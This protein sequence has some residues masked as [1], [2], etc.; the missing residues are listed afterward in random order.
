MNDSVS[1]KI[2]QYKACSRSFAHKGVL[3]MSAPG[4]EAASMAA[5]EPYGCGNEMQGRG[6]REARS[7]KPPRVQ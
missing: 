5:W 1:P 7:A 6:K 4:G 2:V 3:S